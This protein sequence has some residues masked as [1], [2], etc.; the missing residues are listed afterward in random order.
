MMNK[1]QLVT[2]LNE[3]AIAAAQ[4]R[5]KYCDNTMFHKGRERAFDE[6]Y[7]V[8]AGENVAVAASPGLECWNRIQ[9]VMGAFYAPTHVEIVKLQGLFQ[10]LG[11][12]ASREA[13]NGTEWTIA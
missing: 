12:D 7:C 6:A 3:Q 2:W 8:F 5:Q 4:D 11:H 1:Q 9:T 13:W 10:G